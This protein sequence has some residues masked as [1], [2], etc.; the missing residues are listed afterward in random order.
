MA[1]IGLSWH[2]NVLSVWFEVHE[3]Q[4]LCLCLEA[5]YGF[6]TGPSWAQIIGSHFILQFS[7]IF[8]F[9]FKNLNFQLLGSHMQLRNCSTLKSKPF[10]LYIRFNRS[11]YPWVIVRK[12]CNLF[13]WYN[14]YCHSLHFN[15]LKDVIPKKPF[16]TW[17]MIGHSVAYA[18]WMWKCSPTSIAHISKWNKIDA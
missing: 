13:A 7:L 5:R 12:K 15:T 2:V 1:L 4:L 14:C 18:C 6:L 11:I 10:F 8:L 3:R 17:N 16:S 9:C